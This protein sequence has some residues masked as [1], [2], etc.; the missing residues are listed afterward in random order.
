MNFLIQ[1]H[2]QKGGDYFECWFQEA[3]VQCLVYKS[4]P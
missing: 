2:L 4:S 3:A 1:N